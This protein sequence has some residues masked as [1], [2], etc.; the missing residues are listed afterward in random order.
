MM[1][2]IN[3]TTH[4]VLIRRDTGE[5]VSIPPSGSV[6]RCREQFLPI[7]DVEYEGVEIPINRV[8]YELEGLPD[9]EP[10]VFYIVSELAAK[11]AVALGRNDIIVTAQKYRD[12]AGRVYACKSFLM[13]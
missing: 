13:V 12:N 10:G 4:S 11:A 7:V 5:Q 8:V 6:A 1:K 2:L 3:L 9:C